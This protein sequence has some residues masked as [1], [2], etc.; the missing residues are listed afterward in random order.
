ML[1]KK[2]KKNNNDTRYKAKTKKKK[3]GWVYFSSIVLYE[4]VY[5]C[6]K[7]ERERKRNSDKIDLE[8]YFVYNRIC[9]IVMALLHKGLDLLDGKKRQETLLLEVAVEIV[10]I[11]EVVSPYERPVPFVHACWHRPLVL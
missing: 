2:E 9:E 8:Y 1:K 6:K 10:E 3:E 7:K 5:L 4:C 11:V